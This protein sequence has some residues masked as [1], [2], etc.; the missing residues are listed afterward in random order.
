MCD[1][2]D[3]PRVEG[4]G[5]ASQDLIKTTPGGLLNGVTAAK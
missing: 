5:Y 3:T 1:W 2:L 4:Q